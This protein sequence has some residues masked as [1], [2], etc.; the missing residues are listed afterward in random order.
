MGKDPWQVPDHDKKRNQPRLD[1]NWREDLHHYSSKGHVHQPKI[2]RLIVFFLGMALLVLGLSLAFPITGGI[3]PYLLRSLVI[4]FIFGGAAVFWSRASLLKIAK[5]AGLWTIII[6]G[7]S[8]FYLSQSD[9]GNR[10]MSA[11]D[12]SGVTSTSDGMMVHRSRDGHFWLRI[13][14]NG[15]PLKFMVDTGASNIVLSPDDAEKAGFSAHTLTY[16]GVA[17]TANGSVRYARATATSLQI[18]DLTLYDVPVTVNGAKMDG[19]LLG[20]SVLKRFSSIEFRGDTLIL[21]P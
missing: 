3:D 10:F 6:A 5:V 14:L 16:N 1:E 2:V 9:L 11:I 19:S 7:L 4:I 20:M 18:G 12:P 17:Q 8:I 21:R 15:V 13:N